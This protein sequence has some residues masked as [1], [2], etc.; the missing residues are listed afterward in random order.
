MSL[1]LKKKYYVFVIK[2]NTMYVLS[3]NLALLCVLLILLFTHFQGCS[4]QMECQTVNKRQSWACAKW[5]VGPEATSQWGV[6]DRQTRNLLHSVT[7]SGHWRLSWYSTIRVW[8][9]HGHTKV[10]HN[11]LW[12]RLK[13][14]RVIT[15][16][17]M[18]PHTKEKKLPNLR[19]VN[20]VLCVW[21]MLIWIDLA[22]TFTKN[23][24]ALPLITMHLHTI[25]NAS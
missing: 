9:P 15:L 20:K 2:K 12:P 4:A 25:I 17:I 11:D 3:Q 10:T 23:D 8:D 1:W 14:N 5:D 19:S 16:I 18:P 6:G 7:L 22:L 21:P 24:R 13:I